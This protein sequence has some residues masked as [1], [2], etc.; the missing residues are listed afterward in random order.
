MTNRPHR[1]IVS[2]D[3][4][5]DITNYAA[6]DTRFV[7]R[8]LK[9]IDVLD[10]TTQKR[11]KEVSASLFGILN[12]TNA[13]TKY[14]GY[15]TGSQIQYVFDIDGKRYFVWLEIIFDKTV[16]TQ[17]QFWYPM[18]NL[19]FVIKDKF[20]YVT[21]TARESFFS[22]L[23]TSE[24]NVKDKLIMLGQVFC[25]DE[26]DKPSECAISV[27]TKPEGKIVTNIELDDPTD[28]SVVRRS[29]STSLY[30]NILPV[31]TAPKTCKPNELVTVDVQFYQGGTN[32]KIT[33]T[34][35]DGLVIEP[36]SG[37]C[38]HRRC[39]I[40]N[41]HGQF[42]IRA[43]DLEKGDEMRVKVGT[44]FFSSKAECKISVI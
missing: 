38:P 25:R 32:N 36:V 4:A 24:T 42:K 1:H 27:A 10:E 40:V 12:T 14:P 19:G 11:L 21:D 15:A 18:A 41:G 31:L 3:F 2:K 22:H 8:V 28:V 20:G 5:Y 23:R 37:Y 29:H 9:S 43:L 30:L 13:L 16:K 39:K 33:E 34:N 6:D 7:M 17:K 44:K 35:W 26:S